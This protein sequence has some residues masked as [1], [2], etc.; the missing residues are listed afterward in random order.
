MLD[1]VGPPAREA[2]A[3]R[4]VVGQVGVL[5]MSV[6][7]LTPLVGRLGVLA[8]LVERVDR[9]PDLG[10]EARDALW[11]VEPLVTTRV[12]ARLGRRRE[13]GVGERAD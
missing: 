10:R 9:P 5:R 11:Q 7:Q 3:A 12:L 1:R 13:L 8:R 6:E 4:D 2:L